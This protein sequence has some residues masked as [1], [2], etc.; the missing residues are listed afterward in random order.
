MLLD[1]GHRHD[2]EDR[3]GIGVFLVSYP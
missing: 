2:V 3:S 1:D